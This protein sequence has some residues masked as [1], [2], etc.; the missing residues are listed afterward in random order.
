MLKYR[1]MN[2]LCN[3]QRY[4]YSY[5][6]MNPVT[7][8][9]L[10]IMIDQRWIQWF[11]GSLKIYP[12]PLR[13]R[14]SLAEAISKE[15]QKDVAAHLGKSIAKLSFWL[16]DEQFV[17]NAEKSNNLSNVDNGNILGFWADK[18]VNYGDVVSENEGF[19]MMAYLIAGLSY[20]IGQLLLVI[21]WK[22]LDYSIRGL[23]GASNEET[24]KQYWRGGL[25]QL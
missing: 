4:A 11:G 14:M 19:Q 7:D 12:C 1:A 24:Y 18:T 13:E 15:V 21:K 23:S 22:A 3:K 17:G 8:V 6:L 9:R 20:R 16:W 10:H 25:K 5:N 2:F